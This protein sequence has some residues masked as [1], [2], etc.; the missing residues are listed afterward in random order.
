MGVSRLTIIK[1]EKGG[2]EASR[3]SLATWLNAAEHLGLID[4][5]NNVMSVRSDPFD[6]YDRKVREEKR[7]TRG[8]VK[9]SR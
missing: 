9:K 4:T 8:R 6:E 1:M 5:W 7:I 2:V 3:I